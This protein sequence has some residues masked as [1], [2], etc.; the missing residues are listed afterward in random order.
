[1]YN[2]QHQEISHIVIIIT[3]L[4]I[5]LNQVLLFIPIMSFIAIFNSEST[6]QSR[7][8]DCIKLSRPFGLFYSET[9]PQLFFVFLFLDRVQDNYFIECPSVCV[10]VLFPYDGICVVHLWQALH[11]CD[12]LFF[13]VLY[14]GR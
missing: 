6:V 8:I 4:S 11:K 3:I 2:D 12:V 10:C 14:I 5:V 9:M 7:I 1:M 13:S